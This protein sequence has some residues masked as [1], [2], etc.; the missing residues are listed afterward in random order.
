M[1]NVRFF[2]LAL[3]MFVAV[4]FGVRWLLTPQPLQPD[5]RL[6]TFQRIE[7]NSAR[8]QLEASSI[9]DGDA[10]R[11]KLRHAVLDDAKALNDDPCNSA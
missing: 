8:A 4:F 11:D 7:P 1:D 9:S 6:S 5:A 10:T 3:S 2:G